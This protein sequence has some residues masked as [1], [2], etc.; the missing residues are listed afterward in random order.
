MD[1][2]LSYVRGYSFGQFTYPNGGVFGPIMR[3]YFS[4]LYVIEGMCTLRTPD[5][6][7]KINAGQTGVAATNSRFNFHYRKDMQTAAIW[8]EGFLPRLGENE[9]EYMNK[10]Y[11]PIPTPKHLSDLLQIGLSTGFDSSPQLNAMRDAIGHAT[12]RMFLFEAQQT[13]DDMSMPPLVLKARR[14]IEDNLEN[15]ALDISLVAK[16]AG[17]TQQHLISSYK[18]HT[19]ITPSRYLWRLR[20]LRARNL[21]IH[22]R[23]SQA[24]IAFQCGFKSLPHFS[25][26]IR[27]SFG[28]T[29]AELRSDMGFTLSSDTEVKDILF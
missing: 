29:P 1:Q 5:N 23:L 8:C 25:R 10:Q 24:E 20:A 12:M 9:F 16:N 19:N 28:M 22:T 15:E 21:L 14:F 18:K 4:L 26:S 13:E 27:K 2:L 6:T 7:I 11:D 17:V 3:P